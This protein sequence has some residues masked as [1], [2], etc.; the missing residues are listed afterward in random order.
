MFLQY[1][2]QIA[3]AAGYSPR[4]RKHKFLLRLHSKFL[5]ASRL[6]FSSPGASD[7]DSASIKLYSVNVQGHTTYFLCVYDRKSPFSLPLHLHSWIT[8][9]MV[10]TAMAQGG[11]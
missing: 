11:P 4:D 9:Q 2:Q 6:F 5:S 8:P 3:D 10:R 7:S 1:H